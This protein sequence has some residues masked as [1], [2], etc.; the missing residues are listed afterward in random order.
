[1]SMLA[2]TAPT[3]EIGEEQQE[4]VREEPGSA[5]RA[6]LTASTDMSAQGVAHAHGLAQKLG[7]PEGVVQVDPAT[8][9]REY[10]ALTLEQNLLLAEWATESGAHAAMARDDASGLVSVFDKISNF[11]ADFMHGVAFDT[12]EA[13]QK[14]GYA[15]THGAADFNRSLA[16]AALMATENTFGERS[17]PAQWSRSALEWVERNR[18]PEVTADSALAQFA[19]DFARSVPQQAG[20]IMAAFA[21]PG[22]ALGVMGMQIAGGDYAELRAKG[23]SPGRAASPSLLDATV[24]APMERMALDKVLNIFKSTG[25]VD[26][27]KKT[28]GAAGTEFITEYLQKAPELVSRLW[29]EAEKHGDTA[30]EQIAWFS[31]T[32]FNADTLLQAHKEGIYEGLIGAA[33]G[34]L[35]GVGRVALDA[36][37]RKMRTQSFAQ[38]QSE[39]HALVESTNTKQ[40]SPPYMQDALEAAGLNQNI[41]MPAASVLELYQQGTDIL[42]PL[43]WDAADVQ[44]AAALGQDIEVPLSRLHAY[45]D[46][47]QFD[48]VAPIMREAADTPN[49]NE[50]VEEDARVTEVAQLTLEEMEQFQ[51]EQNDLEAET[52]RLRDEMIA[53]LQSVPGLESQIRA[54]ATLEESARDQG[55]TPEKA[56]DYVLGLHTAFARRLSEYGVNPADYLRKVS[57]AGLVRDVRGRL[58]PASEATTEGLSRNQ[59]RAA[60]RESPVGDTVWGQLDRAA[61][62]EN[63][64]QDVVRAIEQRYGRGVFAKTT[65]KKAKARKT[66]SN[67]S[68]ASELTRR[69]L[70]PEGATLDDMVNYLAYGEGMDE[71]RTFHQAA[72]Y[73]ARE[74]NIKDFLTRVRQEG[75]KADKSYYAFTVP[76]E[77]EGWEIR[78][79]SDTVLHQGKRHPDM[80][81]D[82]IAVLPDVLAQ[83]DSESTVVSSQKGLHGTPFLGQAEINGTT[84]GVAFEAARNGNIYVTTFFKDSPKR[85]T[86]W[87]AEKKQKASKVPAAS[88]AES[89][90]NPGVGL[91]KPSIKSLGQVLEDVKQRGQGQTLFQSVAEVQNVI[92]AIQANNSSP[93]TVVQNASDLPEH[94]RPYGENSVALYDPNTGAVWMVA[95]NIESPERAAQAWTHEQIVHHGLRGLYSAEERAVLMDDLWEKAG[96]LNNTFVRDIVDKYGLDISTDQGR[97]LAMEESLAALAEKRH[98][99]QVFTEQEAGLWQRVVEAVRRALNTLLGRSDANDLLKNTDVDTLLSRLGS[100]VL[101]GVREGEKAAFFQHDD[102]KNA[103]GRVDITDDGYLIQLFKKADLSTLLHETGHVFLNEV[104]SILEMGLGDERLRAD[105]DT[106][107]T[108]LGASPGEAFTTEQHEKFARGFEAWLR[109]GNAPARNLESAFA[110]FKR[111]LT[112][113]YRKAAFLNVDLTDDVRDVFT[114]MLATDQEIE[115]AARE[116]GLLDLTTKELDALGVQGADRVYASGLMRAA[117][118]AAAVRMQ[119]VRDRD[120]GGQLSAWA[121]EAREEINRDPV[122]TAMREMRAEPLD[123]EAVRESLGEDMAAALMRRVP[124]GLKR[125]GIAPE[126]FAAEHGFE[127]GAGFMISQMLDTPNMAQ[128]V[129]E[130]VAERQRMHDV[131]YDPAEYLLETAEAAD[132]VALVGKYIAQAAGSRTVEQAAV[133]RVV[134]ERLAAMPM[135]KAIRAG[136]FRMAM[137]RALGKERRAVAQGDFA[138]ALEANT[139]ARLNMEFARRAADIEHGREKLAVRIRRFTGMSKADPQA[140]FIIMDIAMRHGLGKF[141]ARLAEGKSSETVTDWLRGAEEAGYSLFLNEEALQG[142]LPWQEMSVADFENLAENMNQIITVER[143]RRKLL[144]AQ[145]KSDLDA[146]AKDIAAEIGKHRGIKTLKTIERDPA[147]KKL[148]AGVHA[149]HTKVEALCL[150]LDGDKPGP[151]WEYIY[152]PITEAEDA[153]N[154]RFKAARDALRGA[155]L[156]GAYSRQELFGMGRKKTFVREVGQRLTHENRIALALNMGNAVNI[157]RV[158]DGFGWSDEQIAAVLRPLTKKDWD[159]V[160]SVWDYLETFRQESFTLQ[161]EVT[162]MRPKAVDAQPVQTPFGIYRGGYYP[163]KYNA[164]K[165]F[166]AFQQE[167]AVMDRELF[168]GRNYGAAQTRQGHLKERA[169]G[170]RKNPLLLELSVVTDHVFNVVHDLS[171]RKAVLDVAK[172]IRNSTVR[173]AIEGSVGREMYRELMPWLQAVANERQ[174]PMHYVHRWANWARSATSIM[175]MGFKFTTMFTQPL[176]YTQTVEMLG[177]RWAGYGLKRVYGNPLR[178]PELLEET[179]A[180]SPMMANRIKSFDRDVRDIVKQ[181]R[182]SLGRFGW[183]EKVK[184][185]A[186]TPMG[187][188]QMGVDLP[189]WW[190]AYEKGLKDFLGDE[191]KAAQYADSMVR[192]SQGSGATKDLARV[193]RGGELLRLTTMFY[194]YFNTFYNLAARRFSALRQD[195]S[196]AAIFKAANTALLLWFMPAVLSELVAGR[197]PDDDKEPLEWAAINLLQYPFQAVVGVRDVANAAFGEY[198]YQIT[199][200]QTA[201]TALVKWFKSINKALEEEDA[202]LLA[203]PTAEAVGYVLGLPLKQPI[204][205]VGNVWDYLTGEDP[206]FEVRDL[207]FVKPKSRR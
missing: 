35:G 120:R 196:P 178:L 85:I 67:D 202:G 165:S 12:P 3:N 135:S 132:Q 145:G 201:P 205:T 124:G 18:P 79:P 190:G 173:Q 105:F 153:Q 144:T 9:Q 26:T 52:E 19:Y 23:V 6:A 63:Y 59:L 138:A 137:R 155:K 44:T 34:G 51:A 168:G 78:L 158:K 2:G 65:G 25:F 68:L 81:S 16:G 182:P 108:W 40:L 88:D 199:P 193:Q 140:R 166:R 90:K 128:R 143:N 80:T 122:Y 191:R 55:L 159:F 27:V 154:I 175:Q 107:R 161:E 20:N 171:Y 188:F 31:R 109:E 180:R 60:L 47:A 162:G 160:Q 157:E 110:R 131:L 116:N 8:A 92:D 119:E 176:G 103:R 174:E 17:L 200:A 129:R 82:D 22:T 30:T 102:M 141:N 100:F 87:L 56:T 96:G 126:I 42:A 24:Q 123:L 32:L 118:D 28:L 93:T 70:L 186:F 206:E 4:S 10:T 39:L 142:N 98:V 46:Q 84:Y 125:G 29:G 49:I 14:T 5:V 99:G 172:V 192:M 83:L 203:K 187:M 146:V 104:R 77:L 33:W 179:F 111:W 113:I 147:L 114:R 121:R 73:S 112:R 177:Y 198:D 152:R 164:E 185:K 54:D 37:A 184:E 15:L 94:L 66:L 106:I 48:A 7:L 101:D 97:R 130:L 41:S 189:T 117:R 183:L 127:D 64:G 72:M 169:R 181:L 204:I 61:I 58:L 194:S 89:P 170:G 13:V 86:N 69:G 156:F 75:P 151:V 195:H 62:R 150:A 163:I 136:N 36:Q 38:N 167:Q 11:G 133:T 50:L 57:V 91:G 76:G 71:G 197:G 139:Q 21:S 53:A 134:E 148:T 1:M 149:V 74:N 45:L 43:G 115:T 207:F 95:D